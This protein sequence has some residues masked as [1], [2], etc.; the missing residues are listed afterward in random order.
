MA[1]PNVS[2]AS[3]TKSC[4]PGYTKL[5]NQLCVENKTVRNKDVLSHLKSMSDKFVI[6]VTDK[7]TGVQYIADEANKLRDLS[8]SVAKLAKRSDISGFE[9]KKFDC[10]RSAMCSH[11]DYNDDIIHNPEKSAQAQWAIAKHYCNSKNM[12][13]MT[14]EQLRT[15]RKNENVRFEERSG[16]WT[17]DSKNNQGGD[18]IY[19]ESVRG[20]LEC[21]HK[22]EISKATF[23]CG[24]RL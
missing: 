6:W 4:K 22:G 18:K 2:Q 15:A 17:S 21:Y 20:G 19:C 7:K 10:I 5:P 11:D 16:E 12:Q 14:R 3:V 24:Y 23:R 8:Q 9:I 13:L 1:H